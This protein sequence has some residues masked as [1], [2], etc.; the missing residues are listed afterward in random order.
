MTAHPRVM[1]FGV[2]FDAKSS[3]LRG[4]AQAPQR[5]RAALNDGSGNWFAECGTDLQAQPWH[6]AGDL[7]ET[8]NWGNVAAEITARVE[9][10]LG[11]GQKFL[12]WGGDHSVS[13][14]LIQAVSKSRR[15]LT[16]VHLDA[17]PDVYDEFEG[18]RYSHACPFARVMECSAD[19]R[20]IQIGIRTATQHQREQIQRFGIECHTAADWNIDRLPELVGP[21]YLSLDLDVLDPAFAP[22]VS[23]H[24]PGGLSTRDVLRIIHRLRGTLVA[25][26][27]VEFNPGRDPQGITA[28]AAAK[29]SKEVL[30]A[31][32]A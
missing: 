17:H 29:L 21:V 16:V 14:P 24:E 9:Q 6:D 23:H 4:A 11:A 3:F 25:A 28:A 32:L 18:D 31:L 26:D 13:F 7:P 10:A 19:T 2:P 1:V 20:L 22:G 27:L 5:I 8:D 30:A 12:A 15:P